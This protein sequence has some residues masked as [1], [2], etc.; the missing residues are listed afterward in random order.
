MDNPVPVWMFEGNWH[1]GQS[2]GLDKGLYPHVDAATFRSRMPPF[3]GVPIRQFLTVLTTG[4]DVHPTN[5]PIYCAEFDKA[6]EHGG[7]S[8]CFGPRMMFALDR[9][10]L[11][12][13]FKTLQPDATADEI[14]EVLK[15]YPYQHHEHEGGLWFSRFGNYFP[16]YEVP[17]GYWI[18]GKANDALMAVFVHGAERAEIFAELHA[19]LDVNNSGN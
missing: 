8:H 15:L 1:P 17:Y 16:G 14:A 12:P 18:P 9:T 19:A 2:G 6:W 7:S 3:R 11:K 5:A 4:V 10:M 13:S